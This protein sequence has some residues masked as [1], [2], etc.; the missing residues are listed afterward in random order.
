MRSGTRRFSLGFVASGRAVR[1][2]SARA[3][4]GLA[5][6]P[7]RPALTG[8]RPRSAFIGSPA[9]AAHIAAMVPPRKGLLRFPVSGFFQA[10]VSGFLARPQGRPGVVHLLMDVCKTPDR[11]PRCLALPPFILCPAW[12]RFQRVRTGSRPCVGQSGLLAS[13]FSDV[14]WRS[15]V[16]AMPPRTAGILRD[17]LARDAPALDGRGALLSPFSERSR[18]A[19]EDVSSRIHPGPCTAPAQVSLSSPSPDQGLPV[20]VESCR[21]SPCRALPSRGLHRLAFPCP[22]ARF[23]IA[24]VPAPHGSGPDALCLLGCVHGWY[25]RAAK[26]RLPAALAAGIPSPGVPLCPVHRRPAGTR[27]LRLACYSSTLLATRDCPASDLLVR[28]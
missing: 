28:T 17:G 19:A 10:Q 5:R 15:P 8:P 7:G 14:Q 11:R 25:S 12:E 23:Q 9:I 6:S 1:G 4:S 18:R 16:S 26:T 21:R 24:P 2:A 13:A 22:F 3:C 20:R 27:L